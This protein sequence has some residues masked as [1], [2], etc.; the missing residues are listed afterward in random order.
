MKYIEA[1][2]DAPA[3]GI[4]VFCAG[5]ITNCPNWQQDVRCEFEKKFI[6]VP[7]VLYNPRRENFPINDP[8]AAEQQ[9][10]WEFTQL[11]LADVILFWFSRGSDNPIV[12]YEYGTHLT[13]L[14]HN[15]RSLSRIVCG[16]DEQYTRKSDVII[17]TRLSL[18][19]EVLP[20]PYN[21]HKFSGVHTDF[22]SFLL[23]AV[24]AVTL[25][26]TYTTTTDANTIPRW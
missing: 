9:I 6:H 8:S 4:R 21:R 5:G 7:V 19:R 10:G 26:L 24:K 15:V 1:P 23:A 22:T 20:T 25:E 3:L 12:L 14:L 17:Q 13:R 16:V 2:S 18:S 11:Q